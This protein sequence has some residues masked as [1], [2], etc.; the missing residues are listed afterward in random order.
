MPPVRAAPNGSDGE[1]I[2]PT[3]GMVQYEQ[4]VLNLKKGDVVIG[5]SADTALS[6]E[7]VLGDFLGN[8]NA[9]HVY[10]IQGIPN[11]VLR[12]PFVTS[13]VQTNVCG[14]KHP[15]AMARK[16]SKA[17]VDLR[18]K[19]E[20]IPGLHVAKIYDHGSDGSYVVAEKINVVTTGDQFLKQLKQQDGRLSPAVKKQAD[21]LSEFAL[22]VL[23]I[24]DPKRRNIWPYHIELEA[25]QF[26]WDG[27]HW[28]LLD[29]E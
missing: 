1:F 26:V 2:N 17:Y 14:Y 18:K 10:D 20:N 8:G 13:G 24:K 25:R 11:K 15:L 3:F 12:V 5:K 9:T 29:W 28:V 22:Q 27:N 6:Q 16:F 23:K 7:F 19:Y 4:R 21:D